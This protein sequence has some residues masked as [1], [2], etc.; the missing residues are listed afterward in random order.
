MTRQLAVVVT[1][2]SPARALSGAAVLAAGSRAGAFHARGS[3]IARPPPVTSMPRPQVSGRWGNV[4]LVH[5]LTPRWLTCHL[6]GH[7]A[8]P[9]PRAWAVWRAAGAPLKP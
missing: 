2:R 9:V 5:V 1:A 6:R 3:G 4:A 8:V 7:S